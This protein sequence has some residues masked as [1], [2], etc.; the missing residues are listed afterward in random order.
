[1]NGCTNEPSQDGSASDQIISDIGAIP[2]EREALSGSNDA[3]QEK[4]KECIT[5]PS[6]FTIDDRSS[7][8]DPL[9]G[10]SN[11]VH[12]ECKYSYFF[13]LKIRVLSFWEHSLSNDPC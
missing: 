4:T 11:K 2:C 9:A 8:I 7:Q 10:T 6:C 12:N 5:S 3:D 13:H 1:M